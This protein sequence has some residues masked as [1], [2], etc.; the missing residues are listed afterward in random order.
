MADKGEARDKA[1]WC[2]PSEAFVLFRGFE[3]PKLLKGG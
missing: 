2:N 1:S 3:V